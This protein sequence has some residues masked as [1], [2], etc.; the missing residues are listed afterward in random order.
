MVHIGSKPI[1]WHIMKI[2]AHYGFSDFVL[3]LGYKGEMIKDYFIHYEVMNNDVTIQLGKPDQMCLHSSHSEAGW[4]ITLADTGAKALKGA[5]V[6]RIEKYVSDETFLLT[7]GDGLAD[8]DINRLIQF[9][10][11]H[12]KMV[13]VTGVNPASRFG[14]LKVNGDRVDRFFE[15]PSDNQGGIINGGFFVMNRDVFSL[16]KNVDD[17]DLEYGP[18]EQIATMGELMVYRHD[19]FWSCMDTIRDTE[20]LN[21]RWECGDAAWKVWN[22]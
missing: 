13:T 3:A 17:C 19:G 7:Y 18:L 20:Y 22:S 15:K 10:R 12:G 14:E 6:K 8:I 11:S 4:K 21:S 1:L 2:Y 16:L 5:R 9:H